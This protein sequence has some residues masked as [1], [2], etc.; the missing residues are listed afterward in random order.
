MHLIKQSWSAGVAL[1][2]SKNMQAG[3][4]VQ[5][6][7]LASEQGRAPWMHRTVLPSDHTST[8][9]CRELASSSASPGSTFTPSWC[10]YG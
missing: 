10:T 9:Q 2:N 5:R 6:A 4:L 3:Q 1:D 8:L 7:S